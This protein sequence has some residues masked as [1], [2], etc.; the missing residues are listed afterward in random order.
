MSACTGTRLL[1]K[2][3]R[4]YTGATL[5]LVKQGSI[6]GKRQLDLEITS[7]IKPRPNKTL[8]GIFR[9]KL[10]LYEVAGKPKRKNGLKAM[11]RRQGEPPVLFSNVNPVTTA[12]FIKNR[13]ENSG[14]FYSTVT[15]EVKET[16][17]K[18]FVNYTAVLT[19]PYIID[20]VIFPNDADELT[21]L[22]HQSESNTLLHNSQLY[23]LNLIKAERER[24]DLFLKNNGYFY[25]SPD[26]L[27]FHADTGR[28]NKKIALTLSVKDEAPPKSL[29]RYRINK[30]L[31]DPGYTLVAD[32]IRHRDTLLVD[33]KYFI[34][35]DS[36]LRPVV[37]T[38]SVYFKHNKFYERRD[39]DRTLRRLMGVGIFKYVNIKFTNEYIGDTAFL[40]VYISLTQLHK[41]SLNAQ[42]LGISKSTNY[43]GP[44]LDLSFRNRN[45][46]RGSELFIL[47]LQTGFETQI[48]K[49]IPGQASLGSLNI[50]TSAKLY[51][52][53]FIPFHFS[54]S[55]YFVPKTKVELGYEQIFH[56][57]YF[58]LN[59]TQALFG[60]FWNESD[61]KTHELNP[62]FINYVAVTNTTS[63]FDSLIEQNI[64]LKKNFQQ[65]F[66]IG[67]QYSYTL[68]TQLKKELGSQFYFKGTAEIA[69]NLIN[70]VNTT[71]SGKKSNPENPSTLFGS[72]YSQYTR[73]DIDGRYFYS[74]KGNNKIATRVIGGI[75]IPY[76]N[77]SSLPY[78]K[79]FF[80]GGS[81]SIRAF[82]SRTLGPGSTPSP[83]ADT[84]SFFEQSGDLKL[85]M[86]AEYR[87]GII[88]IVKGAVFTD[89]GNIWLIHDDP[90]RPLGQFTPDF[91][92]ELA[93]G[94]GAGLRFDASFIV[95]RLDFSF[96]LR[97]PWLPETKRWVINQID[98]TNPVWL[99]DNLVLN[100]AIGYPF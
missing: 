13:L 20:S 28:G 82:R 1:P 16:K 36:S 32:S 38:S 34:E 30:I 70:I 58:T 99:N 98:F 9:P 89:I 2:D 40:D 54:T 86:N 49:K 84:I 18:A 55:S 95:V 97:K 21:T 60:Y 24:I 72:P 50:S 88:S 71:V 7:V 3:E 85:E 17:R 62:L 69:G 35:T 39:H 91:Y 23:N 93:V 10:W 77:S 51:F 76:G 22:I 67:S 56:F 4:L 8:F 78:I 65:Q 92:K 14:Y 63:K 59:N 29:R 31:I 81:N 44:G 90:S 26:Y 73:F 43:A 61:T 46:F 47:G 100:I 68:N 41:I 6:Q 80:I 48:A 74:H 25:F 42:L 27:V 15:Y 64:L 75:G 11:L 87:F 96:P 94:A 12:S 83:S 79:Q 19:D 37:V 45:I 66:I 5:K 53:R 33:G 57:N 52:P